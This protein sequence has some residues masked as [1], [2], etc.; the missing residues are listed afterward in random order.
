MNREE[1]K[2]AHIRGLLFGILFV[3][4]AVGLYAI[5]AVLNRLD[6]YWYFLFPLLLAVFVVILPI[7]LLIAIKSSHKKK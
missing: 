1:Q 3:V 6:F 5:F 7:S 4:L 2:K